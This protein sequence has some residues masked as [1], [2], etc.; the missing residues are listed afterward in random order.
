VLGGLQETL[1]EAGARDVSV[2]PL[3]MKKSRPGHLVKVVVKPEDAERVA[4]RLAE[5][6]GTLG[7]REHGAGH[8]FVAD[9]EVVTAT[10]AAGGE[11]HEVGVKVA[12]VGA[13]ENGDGST[14]GHTVFDVSAEYDDALAV[15]R[16][17]GLPVRE[18]LRRAEAAVREGHADR[19]VHVVEGDG[20]ERATEG[21]EYRPHSL[22]EEGFIHCSTPS[23]VV[24]VAQYNY[25]D[26]EDPRLLVIDPDEVGPEIRYEESDD[27]GFAHIYGP[28]NTDAVVEVV[29]FP[30]EDGR[31][32]LPRRLR[33]L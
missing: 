24:G 22:S 26:A 16:E 27:G 28:L 30:R 31:Y 9:R 29:E 10:V 12:S 13:E 20:Y 17:T 19:L 25:P 6:T 1:A 5:E 14:D 2:V 18:V 4:R 8:R 7:V 23:Q 21:G 33:S 11:R 3:T 32:V 15:A